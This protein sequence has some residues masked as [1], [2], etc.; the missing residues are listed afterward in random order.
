[1]GLDAYAYTT[2]FEP[3]C[4]VDFNLPKNVEPELFF[5]WRKHWEMQLIMSEIYFDKNGQ[6]DTFNCAKVVLDLYDLNY[7]EDRIKGFRY[8]GEFPENRERERERD[9]M[10]IKLAREKIA[11]GLTVFYDSWY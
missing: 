4:G 11:Q 6:D 10:F 9:F 2:T 3:D 7:I 5:Q 8:G 1:M